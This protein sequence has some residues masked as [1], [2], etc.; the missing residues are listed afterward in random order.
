MET[1]FNTRVDSSDR[2]A[3]FVVEHRVN[4]GLRLFGFGA[5][6]VVAGVSKGLILLG[7]FFLGLLALFFFGFDFFF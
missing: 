1:L 2:R 5:K 7:G 3:R 6:F 4:L